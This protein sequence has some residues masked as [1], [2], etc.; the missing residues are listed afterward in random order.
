MFNNHI[1]NHEIK[2]DDEV[3]QCVQELLHLVKME[4]MCK[5]IS[6]KKI[7]IIGMGWSAFVRQQCYEK[8]YSG[9]RYL[10]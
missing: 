2:E 1:P 8:I 6:W 3:K 9:E 7:K 10:L 5:Y 4:N